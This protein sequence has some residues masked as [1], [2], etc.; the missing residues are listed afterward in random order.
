MYKGLVQRIGEGGNAGVAGLG[1]ITRNES[2][3]KHETRVSTDNRKIDTGRLAFG[4]PCARPVPTFT[5]HYI[6]TIP[7]RFI[8]SLIMFFFPC[9]ENSSSEQ[10]IPP[11]YLESAEESRPR[12]IFITLMVRLC[13]FVYKEK[14]LLPFRRH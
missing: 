3:L 11:V 1:F 12:G 8:I 10:K 4:S 2:V 9:V 5:R 14:G 7:S 13:F 6:F